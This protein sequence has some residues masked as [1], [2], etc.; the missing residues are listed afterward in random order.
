MRINNDLIR[1]YP[2]IAKFGV[3]VVGFFLFS[4]V[5][6]Y[7]KCDEFLSVEGVQGHYLSFG[8]LETS[9]FIPRNWK[10]SSDQDDG[11]LILTA[12]S[13]DHFMIN[14]TKLFNDDD[15]KD[16][17]LNDYVKEVIR[18]TRIEGATDIS[19]TKVVERCVNGQSREFRQIEYNIQDGINFHQY[20]RLLAKIGKPGDELFLS[21][22][23]RNNNGEFDQ[24]IDAV[25]ARSSFW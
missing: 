25:L 21:I 1:S 8:N 17:T 6:A 23:S 13:G 22:I 19:P 14:V 18:R 15:E 16:F 10:Y 24:N 20:T 9:V 3:V 7:D 2:F 5:R 12:F 11:Y 4:E